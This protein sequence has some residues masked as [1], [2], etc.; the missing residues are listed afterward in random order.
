[1]H[2]LLMSI[3]QT[4]PHD[5]SATLPYMSLAAHK[6]HACAVA[7]HESVPAKDEVQVVCASSWPKQLVCMHGVIVPAAGRPA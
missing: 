5:L 4:A 1:M 3:Q 6:E 7:V 2:L